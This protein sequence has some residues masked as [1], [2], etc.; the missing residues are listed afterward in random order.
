MGL[1]LHPAHLC[2]KTEGCQ[3]DIGSFT[4]G[5][6]RPSG[7]TA[8]LFGKTNL[9]WCRCP[10]HYIDHSGNLAR[11]E[12]AKAES[13]LLETG[14]GGTN[15]PGPKQPVQKAAKPDMLMRIMAGRQ[16]I[17]LFTGLRAGRVKKGPVRILP[18][19]K[20]F[21]RNFGMKLHRINA[22]AITKRL[23]SRIVR[24]RPAGLPRPAVRIDKN[25][26]G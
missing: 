4:E 3:N 20:N 7:C 17:L 10:A 2:G 23:I 15:R 18:S 19:L 24:R 11:V 9:F 22:P 1:W 8:E 25:A 5:I 12:S 26:P 21:R 14:E 6:V 13:G 16:R